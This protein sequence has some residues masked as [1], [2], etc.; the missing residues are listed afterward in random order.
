[1]DVRFNV[2]INFNDE[3]WQL[4]GLCLVRGGLIV[5]GGTLGGY[6]TW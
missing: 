2:N 4:F 3:E 6:L 1:M 5:G